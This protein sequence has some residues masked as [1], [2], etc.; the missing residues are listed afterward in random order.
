L[1]LVRLSGAVRRHVVADRRMAVPDGGLLDGETTVH[2]TRMQLHWLDHTDGEPD[3]E[4]R[5]ETSEEPVTGHDSN[6]W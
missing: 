4:H 1:V 3:S 6:I 2:R 5:G